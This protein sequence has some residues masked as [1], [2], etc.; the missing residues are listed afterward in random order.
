M[1]I[2]RRANS[3]LMLAIV[4]AMI[5]GLSRLWCAPVSVLFC[6]ELTELSGLDPSR[7]ILS[8]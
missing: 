8:D 7:S 1:I 6:Q 2:V 5:G 4:L 3:S